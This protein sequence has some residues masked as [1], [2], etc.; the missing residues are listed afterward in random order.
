[1]TS[2]AQV[3][4]S[5]SD[6]LDEFS[7]AKSVPDADLLEEFVKRYPEYS[8]ALTEFAIELVLDAGLRNRKVT[9]D[10][11][12]TDASVS[13]AMSS[14]HNELYALRNEKG[15][16]VVQSAQVANPFAA[17]DR[18]AIRNLGERLQA[19]PVFVVKLRDRII[20]EDTLSK[21][22]RRRLAKEL[23]VSE[24]V[25]TA[26]FARPVMP[27][28]HAHFKADQKPTLPPKQTFEEAVRSSGL[29]EEQQAYLLSL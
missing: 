22:F 14:F 29:T 16:Q 4:T 18:T 15:D 10:T 8:E 12:S 24:D 13:K 21:G 27:P 11:T 9:E 1:M 7:L 26:H 25:V 5:I 23:D 6:V 2:S 19:N 17:L 20:R 28:P 3:P